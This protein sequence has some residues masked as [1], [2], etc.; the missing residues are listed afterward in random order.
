MEQSKEQIIKLWEFV[1]DISPEEEGVESA[2]MKSMTVTF[3]V[4]VWDIIAAGLQRCISLP[5][6][7][8]TESGAPFMH[9]KDKEVRELFKSI[10]SDLKGQLGLALKVVE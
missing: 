10:K 5:I 4:A 3:P 7:V 2:L 9:Q 1:K 8:M 6:E